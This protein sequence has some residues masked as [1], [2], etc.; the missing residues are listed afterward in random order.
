M[1]RN[2]KTIEI[3]TNQIENDFLCTTTFN[4]FEAH[5]G[6]YSLKDKKMR[7]KAVEKLNKVLKRIEILPFL[8]EDALR[9]ADIV[10]NLRRRGKFVGAD[11]IIAA[12]ALNNGCVL[13]TRNRDHFRWIKEETGLGVVFY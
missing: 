1:I 8:E 10:G 3:V 5:T 6:S 11:A 12:I 2:P 13:V 9:A 4:V 7:K